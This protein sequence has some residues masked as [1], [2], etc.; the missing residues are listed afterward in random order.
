[1]PAATA[2]SR[3]EPV[4]GRRQG[5]GNDSGARRDRHEVRVPLPARNNVKMVM[6]LNTR[7]GR[8]AEIHAHVDTVR[9]IGV[10]QGLFR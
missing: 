5:L 4:P 7:A 1:M 8:L 2:P 9:L 10:P 6:I 3:A